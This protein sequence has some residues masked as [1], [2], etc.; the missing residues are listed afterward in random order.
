MRRLAAGNHFACLRHR[1][2][3]GAQPRVIALA[4][5]VAE[6][7]GGAG[8]DVVAVEVHADLEVVR[9]VVAGVHDLD[10]FVLALDDGLAG[11]VVAVGG[12]GHP[13]A[14]LGV[15]AGA[16]ALVGAEP[17]LLA[18]AGLEV[19]VEVAGQAAVVV[20]VA[21]PVPA[22]VAGAAEV[23]RDPEHLVHV[24]GAGGDDV[25]VAV[26]AVEVDFHLAVGIEI[27][28]PVLGLHVELEDAAAPDGQVHLAVAGGDVVVPDLLH[29][30]V[31]LGEDVPLVGL[32][33]VAAGAGGGG[34]PDVVALDGDG[35]DHVVDQAAVELV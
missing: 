15:H 13:G 1:G 4:D 19:V 29:G 32:G 12:V 25:D 6:A 20:E 26:V 8:P 11:V 27:D 33:V 24:A 28:L 23:G 35:I 3:G 5:A 17:G 30:G 34:A 2:A 22:V 14:G 18:A 7:L 31:L 21:A 16:Q 10:D 9:H